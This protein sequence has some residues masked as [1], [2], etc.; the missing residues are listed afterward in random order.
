MQYYAT[1]CNITS[2]HLHGQNRYAAA[3]GSYSSL[4]LGRLLD[5]HLTFAVSFI[6]YIRWSCNKHGSPKPLYDSTALLHGGS[7]K[8]TQPSQTVNFNNLAWQ[9]IRTSVLSATYCL[10]RWQQITL[11]PGKTTTWWPIHWC[12]N[13]WLHALLLG[14]STVGWVNETPRLAKNCQRLRV[15]AIT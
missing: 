12:W 6:L 13:W 4:S 10:N 11:F 14:S 9:P 7:W 3:A 2:E 5:T 15:Q 1:L 8:N